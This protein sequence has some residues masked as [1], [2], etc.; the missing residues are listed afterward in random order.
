MNYQ[1]THKTLGEQVN[2]LNAKLYESAQ[3]ALVWAGETRNDEYCLENSVGS[4]QETPFMTAKELH[5]YL[6]GALDYITPDK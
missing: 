3:L 1:I 5:Q 2:R 4:F 6:N